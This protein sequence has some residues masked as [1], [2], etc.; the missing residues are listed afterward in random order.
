MSLYDGPSACAIE[1]DGN[2]WC[3]GNL[4]QIGA[5]PQPVNFGK[6][7]ASAGYA[8][9]TIGSSHSCAI[10][11]GGALYCWGYNGNGQLGI[12]S[13]D[14]KQSPTAVVIAPN[15]GWTSVTVDNRA[16]CGVKSGYLLCWGSGY[17]LT[18]DDA[19]GNTL[20]PVQW[21]SSDDWTLV[22]LGWGL[23]GNRRYVWHAAQSPSLT[24]A[25][26]AFQWKNFSS[27]AW[28][29]RT[30]GVTTSGQ[31]V[32]LRGYDFDDGLPTTDVPLL[33]E[34]TTD[35]DSVTVQDYGGFM[36][37]VDGTLKVWGY[38]YSG[39]LGDGWTYIEKPMF[40]AAPE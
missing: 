10:D 17:D 23:R 33:I 35:I 39:D 40:L 3:W 36:H 11:R 38:N 12:N 13:V 26:D 21:G 25:A 34:G 4:H 20:T 14:N 16:S 6:G 5:T 2:L 32:C 37:M 18:G 9:V 28:R 1:T 15:S 7:P 27:V 8:E 29:G 22:H 19:N 31:M 24:V 30:C